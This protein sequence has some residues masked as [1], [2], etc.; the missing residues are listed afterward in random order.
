MDS[1]ILTW[2]IVI[3]V[4]KVGLCGL[5]KCKFFSMFTF[6]FG[7]EER[8]QNRTGYLNGDAEK[9][10]RIDIIR[11]RNYTYNISNTH[12]TDITS[13]CIESIHI[14]AQHVPLGI[15]LLL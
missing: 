8:N 7:G 9:I 14:G 4:Q 13:W 5:P 6:F 3:P 15:S 1:E 2:E 12:E 11:L 10:L